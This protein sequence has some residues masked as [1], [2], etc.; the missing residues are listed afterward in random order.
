MNFCA[1]RPESLLIPAAKQPGRRAQKRHEGSA[2]EL[3]A[4]QRLSHSFLIDVIYSRIWD[5]EAPEEGLGNSQSTAQGIKES[6]GRATFGFLTRYYVGEVPKHD[7][8]WST[9]TNSDLMKIS[10]ELSMFI[11]DTFA[12]DIGGVTICTEYQRD[13]YTFRCHPCYPSDGGIYDWMKIDFGDD[14]ICPCRLAAVVV[15]KSPDDPTRQTYQ[16][17]VQ[18]AI[19]KTNVSSVLLTEWTWSPEYIRDSGSVVYT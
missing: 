5:G 7:V 12:G 13:V 6:T 14:G 16:L 2:F 15:L 11:Y 17:V 1:Q 3:G 19:K 8:E 4:A 10:D 18:S 9:K